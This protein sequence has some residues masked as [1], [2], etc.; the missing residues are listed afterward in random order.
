M[1]KGA[2]QR[3]ETN[4]SS[5]P[6][7]SVADAAAKKKK[8]SPPP[9]STR[10]A[11]P[12]DASSSGAG[13][14]DG[15][16]GDD[17]WDLALMDGRT[18]GGLPALDDGSA[19]ARAAIAER[20]LLETQHVLVR[21]RFA[22][23]VSESILA[24]TTRALS[25][26][27][28]SAIEGVG[29]VGRAIGAG[30][31]LAGET[32]D[33][34]RRELAAMDAEAAA[35]RD[36]HRRDLESRD[37]RLRE[38]RDEVT[39]L[40]SIVSAH[41]KD[42]QVVFLRPTLTTMTSEEQEALVL[43]SRALIERARELEASVLELRSVDDARSA[44]IDDLVR[45]MADSRAELGSNLLG[46]KQKLADHGLID[47]S[48]YDDDAVR[49]L[50]RGARGGG[51]G[52]DGGSTSSEEDEEDVDVDGRFEDRALGV[53]YAGPTSSPLGVCFYATRGGSAWD[54][55]FGVRA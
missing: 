38:L 17:R 9:P 8:P 22:R 27:R 34:L 20:R 24:E 43:S 3:T 13:A 18:G 2:Q 50:G 12:A 53:E 7:S 48:A 51:S 46:L 33:G 40:E 26:V 49:A 23:E 5:V 47:A 6:A 10:D 16:D 25:A 37:A 14:V 55:W 28:A 30:P 39:R 35:T 54:R 29:G 4:A 15:D 52:S 44:A 41:V 45:A 42:G 31:S 11:A 32:R 1:G 21:E 36:A 19:E